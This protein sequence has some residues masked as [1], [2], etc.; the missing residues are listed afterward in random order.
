GQVAVL[1]AIAI[2]L[3]VLIVPR[4]TSSQVGLPLPARRLLMCAALAVAPVVAVVS[5]LHRRGDALLPLDWRAPGAFLPLAIVAALL[6]AALALR[7]RGAASARPGL[8][9]AA[10][11]VPPALVLGLGARAGAAA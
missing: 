6:A 10:A 1:W 7:G 11:L 4:L 2:P 3:A 9:A 5:L 8:V